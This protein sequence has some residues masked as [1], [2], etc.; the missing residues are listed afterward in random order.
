LLDISDSVDFAAVADLY[1]T[2]CQYS[3][4]YRVDDT[5]VT[6]PS[7]VFFL[8]GKFFAADGTGGI[9]QTSDSFQNPSQVVS[10]DGIQILPDRIL[11]KDAKY[12]HW[13]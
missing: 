9:G 3:V 4:L 5:V 12:G 13:L 7:A 8:A 11:E 1:H 2:D 10:G 6:L